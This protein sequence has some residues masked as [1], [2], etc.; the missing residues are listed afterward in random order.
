MAGRR[1][2][3]CSI[4]AIMSDGPSID[5]GSALPYLEERLLGFVGKDPV[6]NEWKRSV[7][8]LTRLSVEQ[9]AFVQCVGMAAPIPIAEIYQPTRLIR[10]AL[11]GGQEEQI[12]FKHVLEEK[13]DAVI[14]AGP[15]RGKTTLLH[16]IYNT[17]AGSSEYVPLLFTLR[18]RN[19]CDTLTDFVQMLEQVRKPTKS[20]RHRLVLLVDGYDE[21]TESKRR[22][23]SEALLTFR[24]LKLGNVLLTCR[25]Y[26]D[27][28]DFKA[29]HCR[30]APFSYRDSLGFVEAFSRLYRLSCSPASLIEELRNHGFDDFASQ[31]LMLAL[32]CVLKSG[33]D[34]DIPRRSIGLI[35]RAIDTL[36]FRWDQEKVVHRSSRIPL[37]G[38]ERVRCLMRIAFSML[39]PQAAWNIVNDAVTAHL[40]LIHSEH[41]DKRQLV[42]MPGR[43]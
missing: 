22:V 33:P 41:I 28:Y 7:E 30:L 3:R 12:D 5:L 37:D 14:F 26:Y 10:P 23:V 9:S 16:W 13:S 24:S 19:A 21:V 29:L 32:V 43:S 8:R 11:S 39:Q 1:T 6:S 4:I 18:G 38:E 34:K 35:R 2:L 36:S 17:L 25:E 27:I 31:P 15:G 20:K 40:D 42:G